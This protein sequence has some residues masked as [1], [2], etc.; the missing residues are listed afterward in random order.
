MTKSDLI[1]VVAGK[2]RLP[3]GK[4][5]LIVNGIF[6]ALKESM[7]RGERIEIRGLGTFEVRQYEGYEGRNPRTGDAV[8]VRPKRLPFFRVGK[9]LKERVAGAATAA[10]RSAR[11]RIVES[12]K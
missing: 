2:L 9:D 7:A 12:A 10:A 5:E 11:S 1:E 4:A 6:D 3:L 8:E